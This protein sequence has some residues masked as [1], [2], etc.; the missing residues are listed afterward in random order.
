MQFSLAVAARMI[1][2]HWLTVGFLLGFIS[3]SL[4]LNQVDNL[5]DNLILLFYVLLATI[6]LLLFYIGVAERGPAFLAHFF[7]KYAPL[8][9]QYSFGGLL[10]GMLIFYGRSGD[11]L[12]SAPFLLLIL[13]V[14]VGN[15][16]VDKRSDRLLYQ[17]ALY[18]I[19][20]F[21]YIVLV[22]PVITG[23]MGNWIFV[24][25]GIAALVLV[26]LVV[27]ILYRI[28]PHFMALNTSR[29]IVTIG[30]IYVGFN[31]LYFTN[32]IPPIPLS[33]TQLAV[34]QSV[35]TVS[36]ESALKSYR[37]TYEEQP[38][39]RRLLFTRPL[40]HPT[41]ESIACF[42][43]VYAPTKLSTTIYHRWEYKDKN[44]DWQEQS[45]I[46][47]GIAGTNQNGYGGY[48]RISNFFPGVWRCSVETEQG[49]VLGREVVTISAENIVPNTKTKIE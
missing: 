35:E 32:L 3:D 40:L 17:L 11:W 28:I 23:K 36:G 6:S 5:I 20:L 47:Y 22:I 26:T 25:S 30:F 44:G 15:E 1:K 18:F 37:V 8:A 43:R 10:S 31:T 41:E 38:W 39:Y 45:R 16:F 9:M 12:A 4:L 2:K 42:A 19:G 27:Q 29:I 34:V 46:G 14:I 24:G 33:L 21:S 49:Q 13:A 48:T 7:H